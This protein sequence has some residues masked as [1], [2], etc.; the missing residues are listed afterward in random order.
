MKK[1]LSA[2]IL[3]VLLTVSFAV[4]AHAQTEDMSQYY[5]M[6]NYL[7]QMAMIMQAQAQQ[8]DYTTTQVQQTTTY[9]TQPQQAV[10][11]PNPVDIQAQQAMM[12]L[13]AQ[14]ALEARQALQAQQAL[15]I[16][17]AQQAQAIQAQQ[18]QQAMLLA[19]ATS[20]PAPSSQIVVTPAVVS[21]NPVSNA[22]Y[23][24]TYNETQRQNQTGEIVLNTKT[25][26][27][28]NPWCSSVSKIAPENYAKSNLSVEELEARGYVKC[29]QNGDWF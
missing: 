27:M 2:L 11:S 20:T 13:Q 8:M 1:K 29:L 24:N 16:Q 12:A 26:K 15:E 21:S 17:Q 7:M 18:S 28:H 4:P 19:Q 5:A 9:P 25:M 10:I 23:F 22:D 3:A 14:Q 6:A